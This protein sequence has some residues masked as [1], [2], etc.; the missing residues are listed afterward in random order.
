MV[1]WSL[2]ENHKLLFAFLL[3]LKIMD[4]KMLEQGGLNYAELRFL[5]AGSTKVDS[6]DPNPTGDNGWLSEK[7]WCAIEE[8]SEL[9]PKTFPNLSKSFAKDIKKWQKIYD[10]IQP[11]KEDPWPGE[12]NNLPLLGKTMIMRILRPDKVT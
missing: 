2:F 8:M 1:S 5:M 11:H 6:N 10:S 3:C 9:F 12:W 4:E 7:N